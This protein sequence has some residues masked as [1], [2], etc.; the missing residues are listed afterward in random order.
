MANKIKESKVEIKYF[1]KEPSK[2][3]EAES[4]PRKIITRSK[5]EEVHQTMEGEFI[6]FL[7]NHLIKKS[8]KFTRVEVTDITTDFS[9][10]KNNEEVI[11]EL[12]GDF[13][14]G[15]NIHSP[16]YAQIIST[17]NQLIQETINLIKDIL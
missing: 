5:F 8:Y 12:S 11:L 14:K 13:M 3:E 7:I 15:N 4:L 17:D 16:R 10:E 9:F 6:A 1:A 2:G